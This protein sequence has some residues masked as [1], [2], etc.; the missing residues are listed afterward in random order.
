MGIIDTVY[1]DGSPVQKV[2]VR[3]DDKTG[4]RRTLAS[5]DDVRNNDLTGQFGGIYVSAIKKFYDIDTENL[6][7]DDGDNVIIDGAG[8]HFVKLDLGSGGGVESIVPGGNISVD[9]TDPA[10]PV[11]SATGAGIAA[12]ILSYGAVA[13][14]DTKYA[15]NKD[16]FDAALATGYP[17][18]V[19]DGLVF[20]SEAVEMPDTAKRIFGKGSIIAAGTITAAALFSVSGASDISFDDIS[21][22]IDTTTYTTLDALNATDC[23]GISI[24]NIAANGYNGILLTGCAE[25]EIVGNRITDFNNIGIVARASDGA[26]ISNNRVTTTNTTTSHYGIQVS[27]GDGVGIY[28]NDVSNAYEF[29]IVVSGVDGDLLVPSKSIAISGNRVRNT[30]LEAINITNGERFSIVGN[31]CE[32]T[33]GSSRDFGISVFG[34]PNTSSSVK[35]G[36]ISGNTIYNSGK[37]GIALANNVSSVIVANNLVHGANALNGSTDYHIEGVLVYGR[38]SNHNSVRSNNIIDPSGHLTWA[39]N[40]YDDGIGTGAPDYNSF[41]DNTGIGT[42]GQSNIVGSNSSI[43]SPEFYLAGPHSTTG[44]G[45]IL[46]FDP[47]MSISDAHFAPFDNSDTSKQGRFQ[48]SGITTG[49][50]RTLTWPDASGTMALKSDAKTFINL[51]SQ[52]GVGGPAATAYFTNSASAVE[53]NITGRAPYAGTFKNLYLDLNTAPGSG[54]TSTFTLR[55]NGVDTAI[56]CQASGSAVTAS[57]TTHTVSVAAGDKWSIKIVG[58]ATAAAAIAHGGIEFDVA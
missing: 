30:G 55:V 22:Q 19:P 57:D 8:N 21:I 38:G 10:N 34:D 27:E 18:Y 44:A 33:N 5:V 47:S 13:G 35:Y 7:A 42:S 23:T 29:G 56:T 3:A 54:Q 6:D 41:A 46:V 16:A 49:Q 14:D 52:S 32:W 40:E 25:Y 36:V 2:D 53:S 31:V 51:Q 48:L 15:E 45:S 12:N 58:S 50:T 4:H 37:A 39:T 28:G 17:V 24:R 43:G 9:N 11:V 20:Y 1:P 26:S